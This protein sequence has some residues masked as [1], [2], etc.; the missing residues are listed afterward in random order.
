MA[1]GGGHS[2]QHSHL[3]DELETSFHTLFS[4]LVNQD[5]VNIVEQDE[6]KTSVEQNVQKFLDTAK[7]IECFFLQRR[8]LLSS[9]RPEQ[10]LKED[11]QELR[12]ELQRKE[13][14]IQKHQQKIAQWQTVL[15]DIRGLGRRPSQAPPQQDGMSQGASSSHVRPP[16]PGTPGT[17]T[18]IGPGGQHG[19]MWSQHGMAAGPGVGPLA[20]LE[21]TA[22]SLGNLGGSFGSFDRGGSF[23]R[24]GSFDRR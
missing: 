10:I 23:D 14:L 21:Q 19:M 16:A 3:V 22:S 17:P 13:A 1:A 11:I 24:A 2:G 15:A 5:H 4:S 7:Q 6:I 8:L 18:M 20:H 9:Q 12:T